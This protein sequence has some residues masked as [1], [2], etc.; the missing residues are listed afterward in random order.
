MA[1]FANSTTVLAFDDRD[2]PTSS[3]G[4][5]ITKE[6]MQEFK[7]TMG[8]KNTSPAFEGTGDLT[9]STDGSYDEK[10]NSL[11]EITLNGVIGKDNR[12][13]VNNTTTYPHRAITYL[14]IRYPK[15]KSPIQCTGFFVNP[16]TV[17]TA[18]HCLHN[19]NQGGW[20]KSVKV[21]PG[22]NGKSHPYSHVWGTTAYS[23]KGWTEYQDPNFDYGAVKVERKLG[24]T[25][26]WLG[27]EWQ[28][29][30]LSGTNVTVQGYPDSKPLGTMWKHSGEII[31]TEPYTIRYTID[32]SPGQ[33]GGP[34]YKSNNKA[35]GINTKEHWV[36]DKKNFIYNSGTRITKSVY[37]NI[38]YWK[39]L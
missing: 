20:V 27:Y 31:L 22:K 8:D 39:G 1:L 5:E 26:G 35:V 2:L 19:K 7:R 32:T 6:E 16:D 37:D 34:V 12:T 36:G 21:I 17:V 11:E 13:R 18:G 29:S 23:V 25:V 28:S 4:K 24:N 38:S 15:S 14:E 30:T 9:P 10:Q 3:D 33:S